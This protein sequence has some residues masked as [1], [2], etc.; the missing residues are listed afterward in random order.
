MTKGTRANEGIARVAGFFANA[1]ALA[2]KRPSLAIGL[3]VVVV[4]GVGVG[5]LPL[6]G[7]VG[8]EHDIAAG[9]VCPSVAA[10]AVARDLSRRPLDALPSPAA[11]AVSGIAFGMLLA[12]VSL[13]VADAVASTQLPCVS[14]VA[15]GAAISKANAVRPW[16]RFI[17]HLPHRP[18]NQ[19]PQPRPRR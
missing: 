13:G 19:N 1:M 11:Q 9:L 7:G 3:G 2:R 12:M 14:C 6:F 10:V 8:Y 16:R 15:V 17:W 18:P 4:H 5:F